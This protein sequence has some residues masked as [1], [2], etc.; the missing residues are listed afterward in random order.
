MMGNINYEYY[1]VFYYVAKYKNITKAAKMLGNN[2]PNIT[3]I[4]NRLEE[5][6]QCTLFIR[7]NRGVEM[8]E[9]GELLFS[10]VE[11]AMEHLETAEKEIEAMREMRTGHISIGCTENALNLF[12]LDKL[13]DFH[14]LY[15]G[16]Q[17]HI[18]NH[19]TPQA[20]Q[21]LKNGLVDCAIVTSPYNVETEIEEKTLTCYQEILV[22]GTDYKYLQEKLWDWSELKD[23][24]LI[25]LSK[26]TATRDFYQQLFL[27]YDIDLQP[28]IQVATVD[29][30]FPLVRKNLGIGFVP[31]N[32]VS[33]AIGNE[34]VIRIPLNLQIPERKVV[35][36]TDRKK[37]KSNIL[38]LFMEIL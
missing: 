37:K 14:K 25:M 3:R 11:I 20:I 34:V 9:E 18:T 31:Q 36:L 4:I 27:K 33:D 30:I 6:L 2:Q 21:A 23:I 22:G 38:E 15:P 19:S 29:Q 32:L 8:T 5:D 35:L 12:L 7:N 24:P 26:S 10:H 28:E 13:A 16:I 1:R 17:I